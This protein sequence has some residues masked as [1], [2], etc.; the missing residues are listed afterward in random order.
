MIIIILLQV[1]VSCDPYDSQKPYNDSLLCK[2][3]ESYVNSILLNITLPPRQNKLPLKQPDEELEDEIIPDLVPDMTCSNDNSV[4][5]DEDSHNIENPT[6]DTTD[7]CLSDNID[8]NTSNSDTNRD[9]SDM[10]TITS[11][12][13]TNDG[14]SVGPV[15]TGG[16]ED[17]GIGEEAVFT[18]EQKTDNGDNGRE[19]EEKKQ[20]GEED[21]VI[22]KRR[23]EICYTS[24]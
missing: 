11:N 20:D 14:S 10:T 21:E 6:T 18:P 17:E 5:V 7:G 8:N 24:I 22:G 13:T 4:I 19:S 15:I 9:I 16:E 12:D 2:H 23:G 1:F 3:V